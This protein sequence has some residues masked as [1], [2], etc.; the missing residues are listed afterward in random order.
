MFKEMRKKQNAKRVAR[1]IYSSP[2]FK[3][4]QKKFE[5]KLGKCAYKHPKAL[6]AVDK[7]IDRMK[8]ALYK[9]YVEEE[10]VK[11][12]KDEEP[13]RKALY[14]KA[15]SDKFF[16]SSSKKPHEETNKKTPLEK[17][18]AGEENEPFEG[19]YNDVLQVVNEYTPPRAYKKYKKGKASAASYPVNLREKMNAFRNAVGLSSS[20][21]L[22]KNEYSFRNILQTIVSGDE[23]IANYFINDFDP[24]NSY[25]AHLRENTNKRNFFERMFNFGKNKTNVFSNDFLLATSEYDKKHPI[26]NFFKGKSLAKYYNKRFYH[27]E[28]YYEKNDVAMSN[29]EKNIA[30]HQLPINSSTRNGYGCNFQKIKTT[31]FTGLLNGSHALI[32]KRGFH[33]VSGVS[34]RAANLLNVFKFLGINDKETLLNFRLALIG[35]LITEGSNSLY[36][37]LEASHMVGV[38]GEEDLTDVVSMD[39]SSISPL[40]KN[41]ILQKC[42]T[43][44]RGKNMDKKALPFDEYFCNRFTFTDKEYLRNDENN[45]LSLFANLDEYVFPESTED[46]LTPRYD[47]DYLENISTNFY[48]LNGHLYMN[49]QLSL[50]RFLFKHHLKDIIYK[51]I[52]SYLVDSYTI[53]HHTYRNSIAYNVSP[54]N[55]LSLT[56][57]PF[58]QNYDSSIKEDIINNVRK[59]LKRKVPEP[60][61]RNN[62]FEAIIIPILEKKYSTQ[63]VEKQFN[64]ICKPVF[65]RKVDPS[66]GLSVAV[67]PFVDDVTEC[68]EI[69]CKDVARELSNRYINKE[70][71]KDIDTMSFGLDRYFKNSRKYNT[72]EKNGDDNPV[73]S[74]QFVLK[75]AFNQFKEG[76]IYT[77]PC[78]ISTSKDLSVAEGFIKPG[79]FISKPCLL[80]ISFNGINA[81]DFSEISPHE[82][83]KEVLIPAGAKFRV[84]Y[85]SDI[86]PKDEHH[87][88]A[89]NFIK[90]TYVYLTE[91][92]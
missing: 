15:F 52:Y 85:V 6:S 61:E 86:G 56:D 69:F 29:R 75:G 8:D 58:G 71:L 54:H 59:N 92:G 79:N 50:G 34:S 40:D 19:Y 53:G 89:N 72:H 1:N 11:P 73:F 7:G 32:N 14:K 91:I 66:E 24:K 25:L 26:L 76:H 18:L 78:Q 20:T 68:L 48:G 47:L 12:L 88:V 57:K 13:Y 81:V 28:K 5:L 87:K 3:E 41:E 31:G 16:T 64:K 23:D 38:K 74:G 80:V 51:F 84:D 9:Y 49:R 37:I 62:D 82:N 10:T 63:Y 4:Y 77:A 45:K 44:P 70:L 42:G 65:D 43:I 30:D 67:G 83:E 46:D 55:K 35:Y 2:E 17:I 33:L 60:S 36:E 90:P 22:D 21:D 27:R 39:A